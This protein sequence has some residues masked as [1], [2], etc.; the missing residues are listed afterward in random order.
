MEKIFLVIIFITGLQ[1]SVEQWKGIFPVLRQLIAIRRRGFHSDDYS[2]CICDKCKNRSGDE[3]EAANKEHYN[4]DLIEIEKLA[5]SQI[6]YALFISGITLIL[7][8]TILKLTFN[9]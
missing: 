2:V 8:Y 3:L 6:I 1:H 7:L 4:N 9:F 5:R